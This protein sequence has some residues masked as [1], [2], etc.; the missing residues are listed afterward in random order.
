MTTGANSLGKDGCRLGSTR[1]L[2]I[3]VAAAKL[4]ARDRAGRVPQIGASRFLV[5][6][7]NARPE[8]Q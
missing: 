6:H 7:A 1:D 3:G 2:T 5:F 8:R 4:S